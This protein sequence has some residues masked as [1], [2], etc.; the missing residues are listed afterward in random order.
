MDQ[1]PGAVQ[2]P[3]PDAA[4]MHNPVALS[5]KPLFHSMGYI[6]RN[7]DAGGKI[8]IDMLHSVGSKEMTGEFVRTA[9]HS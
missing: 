9:V 3:A 7:L 5:F 8:L 6:Q 2:N 4:H 1:A